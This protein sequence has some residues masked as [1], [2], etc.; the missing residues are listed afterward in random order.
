MNICSKISRSTNTDFSLWL[1]SGKFTRERNMCCVTVVAGG[2][3]CWCT[4]A[5]CVFFCVSITVT[6]GGMMNSHTSCILCQSC[7]LLVSCLLTR[8]LAPSANVLA[9]FILQIYCVFSYSKV[10]LLYSGGRSKSKYSVPFSLAG[11]FAIVF[12]VRAHQSLRCALKRMYVNN[13]HD[14]QVC[15]L[16]IQIMVSDTFT[17]EWSELLKDDLVRAVC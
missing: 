12:L 5:S 4:G 8:F 3:C 11:G 16:E 10:H 15:K 17:A 1:D 7:L 9:R 13:E 2:F 6:D 14:L